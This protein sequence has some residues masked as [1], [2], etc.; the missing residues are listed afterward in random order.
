MS[1]L[2]LRLLEARTDFRPGEDVRG[3]A[4]W[5]LET[6]PERIEVRLFWYTEGKGDQDV[7][8]AHSKR[9]SSTALDGSEEFVLTVPDGPLSFS[10]QLISLYWALELVALPGEETFRQPIV[11]SHTDRPILL[12][13]IVL[14]PEI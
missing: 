12:E 3:T 6:P 1:E 11:V 4:S 13:P 5:I 8:I 7:G 9:L 2:N 10:G 14:E